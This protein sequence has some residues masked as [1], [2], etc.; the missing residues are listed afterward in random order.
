MNKSKRW[1]RFLW[2]SSICAV[3]AYPL[4]GSLPITPAV[5]QGWV[6]PWETKEEKP[7]RPPPRRDRGRQIAP[8]GF[9]NAYNRINPGNRPPICLQLEQ[10]LAEEANRGSQSRS[11]LPQIEENIRVARGSLRRLE[12]EL[13]RRECYDTFLFT[14]TLRRTRRC[15]GLDRRARQA[16]RQLSDMQARRQQ[17]LGSGDKSYQNEIIRE[18]AVNRCGAIYQRENR[19]RNPFANFWQDEDSGDRGFRG[20]TFAGLPFAT[21]RTVCVRLC[22]GYYFPVSFSTLPNHFGRDA[23][24]CQ[25]RC[26]APT[27]LY[28]HQNPGQSVDQMV[29][30]QTQRPYSDLKTAFRYRKEYVAGCSCKAAEFIPDAGSGTPGA[31]PAA[32]SSAPAAGQGGERRQLSPVR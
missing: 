25:S 1:T 29:S 13:D 7:R 9:N 32:Q 10:R 5:A 12:R 21:Y 4:V 20:N 18:L 6:F 31:Q 14:K 30:Q 27:E 2:W 3:L 26:A 17:I 24:A 23:N 19:R 8:Q 11:Q 28:F 16:S 22:D 15:V